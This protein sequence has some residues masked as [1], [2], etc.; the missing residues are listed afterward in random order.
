M[1]NVAVQV[2]NVFTLLKSDR[3]DEVRQYRIVWIVSVSI[4][5]KCSRPIDLAN[6]MCI[7]QLLRR[8]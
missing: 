1:T 2:N 5:G 4:V 6:T 3:V 7:S 8:H